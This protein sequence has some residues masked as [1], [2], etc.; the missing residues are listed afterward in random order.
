[1]HT[2]NRSVLIIKPRIPFLDWV[3]AT[4]ALDAP[5]TID[6]LM[7]EQSV[8]LIPEVNEGG[9][10]PYVRRYCKIIFENELGAWG[11][12][13]LW[14]KKLTFE[15]FEEWFHVEWGSEVF[16]L[17]KEKITKQSGW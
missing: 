7:P 17:G 15:L 11:V 9:V 8:Y 13:D 16:D 10:E 5:L 6:E 4:G 14:P 3:N 2:I 1:M 12:P